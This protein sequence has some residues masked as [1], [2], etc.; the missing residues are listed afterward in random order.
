MRLLALSTFTLAITGIAQEA[1]A[2]RFSDTTFCDP[3][4][5]QVCI[6][7]WVTNHTTWYDVDKT[8]VFQACPWDGGNL[9]TVERGKDLAND[10]EGRF[11]LNPHCQYAIEVKLAGCGNR[12][13][14]IEDDDYFGLLNWSTIAG[15]EFFTAS[16]LSGHDVAPW[17]FRWQEASASACG[18]SGR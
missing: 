10:Q 9:E 4:V 8:K 5:D 16:S 15:R 3:D 18:T 1:E 11:Y 14:M 17:A 13:E 6:S 2:A 7:L 12:K